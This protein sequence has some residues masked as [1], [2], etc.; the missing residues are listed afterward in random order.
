M[1]I[2]MAGN[3][4]NSP[5][6]Q[7]LNLLKSVSDENIYIINEV[8]SFYQ[9][10]MRVLGVAAARRLSHHVFTAE[11]LKEAKKTLFDLWMELE[12]VNSNCRASRNC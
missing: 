7:G 1:C 5:P 3:A 8:C 10:K 12:K 9:R 2:D 6:P 4:N 11:K